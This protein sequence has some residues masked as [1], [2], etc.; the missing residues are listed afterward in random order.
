MVEN[1]KM[2]LHDGNSHSDVGEHHDGDG[3]GHDHDSDGHHKCDGPS[4]SQ[5]D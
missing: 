1:S 2:E 4:E 5:K 3:D